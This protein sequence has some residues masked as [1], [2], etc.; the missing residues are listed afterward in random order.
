MYT[1]EDMRQALE[2]VGMTVIEGKDLL[3]EDNELRATAAA[4]EPE[5]AKELGIKHS[6]ELRL[7]FALQENAMRMMAF[8][9]SL[10]EI[11][12]KAITQ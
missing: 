10:E 7:Y 8:A 9:R 5:W 4:L 6:V 3:H 1:V 2:R 11:T 12:P